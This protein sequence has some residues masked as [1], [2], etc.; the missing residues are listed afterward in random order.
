MVRRGKYWSLMGPVAN[1]QLIC[2]FQ[3][4]ISMATFLLEVSCLLIF[5][6][7][8]NHFHHWPHTEHIVLLGLA[9]QFCFPPRYKFIW[10]I[11]ASLHSVLQLLYTSYPGTV[12]HPKA[13]VVYDT[14][15][16]LKLLMSCYCSHPSLT[17]TH[18]YRVS[19]ASSN[20]FQTLPLVT[21]CC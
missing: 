2:P 7:H 21:G 11:E 18:P 3:A 14:Q 13:Y 12:L 6:V 9:I 4:S 20:H 1:I 8:Y 19:S 15:L 5:L 17:S 16:L 10:H